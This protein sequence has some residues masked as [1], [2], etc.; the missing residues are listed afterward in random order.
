[1]ETVK[2]NGGAR[3][4]AGRKPLAVPTGY[5]KRVRLTVPLL[6]EIERRGGLRVVLEAALGHPVEQKTGA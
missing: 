6:D 5:T 3:P 4:G 1:M 2:K